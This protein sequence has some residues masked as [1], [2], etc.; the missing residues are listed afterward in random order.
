MSFSA[1]KGSAGIVVDGATEKALQLDRVLGACR[2]EERRQLSFVLGCVSVLRLVFA[3]CILTRERIAWLG[4]LCGVAPSQE[5]GRGNA[6]VKKAVMYA[7]RLPE[8]RDLACGAY[9]FGSR[10]A[11]GAVLDAVG[12]S[13][14]GGSRTIQ[15]GAGREAGRGGVDG[16]ERGPLAW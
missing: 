12:G 2:V 8:A 11:G 16:S 5:P 7:Y 4:S 10:C 3:G 1:I 13:R 9:V 14:M 15:E 6:V